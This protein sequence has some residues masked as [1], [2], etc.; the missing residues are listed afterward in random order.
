[1]RLRP[2]RLLP[3]LVLAAGM[4]GPLLAQQDAGF[5]KDSDGQFTG[6]AI[7]TDDAK[8]YE[9]FARPETPQITGKSSF[10]PGEAGA[11][12]LLF[13][14]AKPQDGA[15]EIRCDI[16][17]FDPEG[18]RQIANGDVCYKGPYLGPNILHPTLVDLRFAMGQDEPEGKA[19]FK[20]TMRDVHS[21]R[22]V[23]LN[24]SFTQG[25]QP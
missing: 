6:L 10:G 19:G 23:D 4:S 25:G 8:W 24:V 1:M 3:A 22:T 2:A 20:I 21:G 5:D 18:S 7:I 14:N 13:S 15:A 17:A 9:Q 11:L 12:A 16:T